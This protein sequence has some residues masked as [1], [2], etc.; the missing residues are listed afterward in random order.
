MKRIISALLAAICLA[1]CTGNKVLDRPAFK[2]ASSI[3]IF[4]VKVELTKEATIVHFH[5]F[6]ADWRTWDM[7][8]ARLEADGQTFACQQGRIIT[9]EGQEVLADEAFEFGKDYEKD[10]R[11]DSVI[12]Y[13]EPLPREQRPSII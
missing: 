7:T 3:D 2:S 8:G 1:A 12:L 4:P 5:I 11:K 9:H 13:F 10:A 6:C